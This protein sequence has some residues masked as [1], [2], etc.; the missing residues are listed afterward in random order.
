MSNTNLPLTI[1]FHQLDTDI[2]LTRRNGFCDITEL[3]R[4]SK[5]S[6]GKF[7]ISQKE[8]IDSIKNAVSRN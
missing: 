2:T 5:K 8:I 1:T 3:R 6:I 7:K 4:V